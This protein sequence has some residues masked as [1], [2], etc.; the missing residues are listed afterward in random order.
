MVVIRK[1]REG[2]KI[3]RIGSLGGNRIGSPLVTNAGRRGTKQ[4]YAQKGCPK[5][6]QL[7]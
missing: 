6:S 7:K 4:M 3:G 5:N 2:I 1:R